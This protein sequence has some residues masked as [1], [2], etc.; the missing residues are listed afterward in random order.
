[1]RTR[2]SAR[3]AARPGTGVTA[4]E[5]YGCTYRK[6]WAVISRTG[7]LLRTGYMNAGE[8]ELRRAIEAPAA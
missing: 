3:G 1:M 4:S 2:P 5:A 6:Y 8:T 7:T